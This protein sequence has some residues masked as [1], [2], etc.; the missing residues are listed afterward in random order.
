[1]VFAVIVAVCAFALTAS[2]YAAPATQPGV[3]S[4]GDA[5]AAT[6]D[7]RP[8]AT[9]AAAAGVAAPATAPAL[10]PPPPVAPSALEGESIRRRSGAAAGSTTRPSG[11][12]AAA[13]QAFEFRRVV[14]ALAAVIALIFGL[15]WVAKKV[16]V[17]PGG[18]RGTTRAVQVLSRAPLAPKQQVL[19]LQVGR[20]IVVVADS[21]GQMST[22]CQIE[23]P[24]EVTSLV[25]QIMAE[26]GM[27]TPKSF[28]SVFGK[29]RNRFDEVM[30]EPASGEARLAAANEAIAADD[31]PD[32]PAVDETR[33]EIRGLMDK[34]RRM[35]SQFRASRGET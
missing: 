7:R 32:D 8:A 21:A 28:G 35:S 4:K 18:S 11:A 5:R 34:V 30:D 22:L 12:P 1:V 29:T 13:P 10:T 24:E 33:S 9:A 23:D 27:A 26:R 19:L 2:T 6:S 17:M 16:F 3:A 14:T 20:R 25:G 31:A 15:R